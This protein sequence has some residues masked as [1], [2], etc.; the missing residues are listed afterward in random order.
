MQGEE[1]HHIQEEQAQVL[2]TQMV[3]EE[4]QQPQEQAHQIGGAG[5][6]G[7]VRSSNGSGYGQISLGG[8]GNPSG[9]YETYRVNVASYN[10]KRGT[11]GL[12]IMYADYLYNN[13]EITANGVS[14]STAT[15]SSSYSRV[16]PGGASR[17]RFYKYI[18]KNSSKQ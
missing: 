2:Q 6:K 9:G 15:A 16:D 10:E 13:G 7:I 14:S 1:E 5:S 3:E 11:G 8:T 18:C 17:R 12:L 4:K